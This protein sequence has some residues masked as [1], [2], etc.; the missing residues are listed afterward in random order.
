MS[1]ILSLIEAC[2]DG[3]PVDVTETFKS[4]IAD[5]VSALL[6]SEKPV[7]VREFFD[8]IGEAQADSSK[9]S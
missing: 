9:T 4:L 2:H 3:K 5:R 6:E 8:S 7:V 1:T